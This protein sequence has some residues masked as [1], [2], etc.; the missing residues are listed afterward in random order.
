MRPSPDPCR[1]QLATV[2]RQ[3]QAC[4]EQL[5]S[6]LGDEAAALADRDADRLEQLITAK[7]SLMQT[8]EGLETQRV[9]C[10][11]AAGFKPDQMQACLAWCDRDNL[12][13]QS[14][15]KLL[16][17][18]RSCQH[19]NRKIGATVEASRRHVQQVL[20]LL[21]GQ[22][23]QANLYSASGTQTTPFAA[24]RPLAKV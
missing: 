23:P 22:S 15:H 2:L 3:Q 16:D 18:L 10:L 14:W 21:R 12:L 11:S 4:C 13:A 19:E 5:L 1:R 7:N 17:S 24:S 20:G 9:Q 6:I 8:F